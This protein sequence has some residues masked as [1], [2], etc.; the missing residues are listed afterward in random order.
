MML[1]PA[2][3]L[4]NDKP[5][6]KPTEKSDAVSNAISPAES[7][8][9]STLNIRFCNLLD[10]HRRVFLLMNYGFVCAKVSVAEAMNSFTEYCVGD[11][12]RGFA[13]IG[14]GL[15]SPDTPLW[16]RQKLESQHCAQ[17]IVGRNFND[18]IG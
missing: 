11:Y 18:G 10:G 15:L 4:R 13:R 7:S 9:S 16:R 6:T 2:P 5:N 8:E 1:K 12:T 14:H 3:M 17:N